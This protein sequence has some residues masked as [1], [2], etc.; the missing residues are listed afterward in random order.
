MRLEH[1]RGEERRSFLS[2]FEWWE[3]TPARFGASEGGSVPK[4]IFCRLFLALSVSCIF[5]EREG[6]ISRYH[7]LISTDGSVFFQQFLSAKK[8]KGYR[9]HFSVQGSV[10]WIPGLRTLVRTE[11]LGNTLSRKRRITMTTNDYDS[12]TR[13]TSK[14]QKP[15][16]VILGQKPKTSARRR[17][18]GG[19]LRI[20]CD[21]NWMIRPT[22]RF[23]FARF[24]HATKKSNPHSEFDFSLQKIRDIFLFSKNA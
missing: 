19:K 15:R 2:W 3:R 17:Q 9:R 4:H 7:C 13:F 23:L 6:S 5:T 14:V 11:I 24:W 10:E 12:S 20:R 18:K 21:P 16:I 22:K 8:P 1:R